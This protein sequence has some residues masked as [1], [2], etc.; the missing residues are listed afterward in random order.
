MVNIDLHRSN[1]LKILREIYSDSFLRL[2]L[3]FKGGTAAM[4]FYGLPRF[5]VDL[6]FD[7]F[8]PD[9]K[10]KVFK[11]LKEILPRFGNVTQAVDKQNTLFFLLN[12]EKG[13]RGLKID[14]SKRP[15]RREYAVKNYLGI[16]MMVM[17]EADMA[18][19][20]LSALLTRKKFASRDIFDVWYFLKENWSIDEKVLE[21]NTGMKLIEV[22]QKAEEKV[23]ALKKTALLAG[24]GE[25]VD[26]KQK[27]FVKEK[28]KD[29][30]VFLLRLYRDKSKTK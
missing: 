19:S 3:G 24:L 12:Y 4:L 20:K 13:G 25:F 14:I 10:E 6:D 26:N 11:R 9:K 16:S 28:L 23:M 5:S 7:L 8:E 1:L 30:L 17:R 27:A 18:A 2:S 22:L 29:E 21:E 15:L